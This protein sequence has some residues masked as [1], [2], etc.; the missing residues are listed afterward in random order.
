MAGANTSSI[1]HLTLSPPTVTIGGV[2]AKVS[3]Y[4]EAQG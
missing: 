3:F 1:G 4:G 2:T